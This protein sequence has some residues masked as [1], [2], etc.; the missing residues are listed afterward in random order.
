MNFSSEHVRRTI[1]LFTFIVDLSQIV[2]ETIAISQCFDN[3]DTLFKKKIRKDT[4]L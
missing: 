2:E 3:I 1:K 4:I